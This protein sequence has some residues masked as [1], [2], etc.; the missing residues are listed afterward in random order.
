MFDRE[1]GGCCNKCG[2]EVLPENDAVLLELTAIYSGQSVVV[3]FSNRP[4]HLF[5]VVHGTRVVC[6][7]SP[8]MAQYLEGQP[9]DYSYLYDPGKEA[10]LRE[11]FKK[12]RGKPAVEAES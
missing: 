11:A 1:V 6:K 10:V 8:E 3:L 12:M 4:R 2:L 9:R 7:G 5:P